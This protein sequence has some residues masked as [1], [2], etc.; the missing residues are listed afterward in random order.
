MRRLLEAVFGEAYWALT[1]LLSG[2]AAVWLL[3]SGEFLLGG[4][5]AAL[6]VWAAVEFARIRRK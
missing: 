5:I 2:F 3:V 4:I 6:S 1:V